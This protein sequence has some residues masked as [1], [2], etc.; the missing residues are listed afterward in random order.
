MWKY[1]LKFD[2]LVMKQGVLHGIYITN[3]VES[4]QLVLPREYQKALLHM[5]DDYYSH[6]GL[7]HTMAL[8]RERFYWS[9]IY[10]D[11]TEFVTNCHHCHIVTGHYTGPNTQQGLLVAN[12]P[13][14]LFCIDFLKINL[15]KDSK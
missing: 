14:D 1:L 6:Q 9:K 10:Q 11:I 8:V 15:S 5:L 3:D 2:Q 13:L 7:D 4:Q 12:N